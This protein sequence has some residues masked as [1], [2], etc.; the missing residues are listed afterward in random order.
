[1]KT[2]HLTTRTPKNLHLYY[3]LT[4]SAANRIFPNSTS[5]LALFL[6][7][8]I[9]LAP[10]SAVAQP[11]LWPNGDFESGLQGWYKATSLAD[12]QKQGCQPYD[13][14]AGTILQDGSRIPYPD[15]PIVRVYEGEHS[16]VLYSGTHCGTGHKTW[17]SLYSPVVTRPANAQNLAFVF[18]A[19]G[20]P[21]HYGDDEPPYVSIELRVNGTTTSSIKFNL[22]ENQRSLIDMIHFDKTVQCNTSRSGT[23]QHR[24]FLASNWIPCT[25][26]LTSIPVGAKIQ[27][28]FTVYNC[29]FYIHGSLLAVDRVGYDL[30]NATPALANYT[31]R[32]RSF[33]RYEFVFD[34]PV[35]PYSRPD[36]DTPVLDWNTQ[37][38]RLFKTLY[39]QLNS[40]FEILAGI[41]PPEDPNGIV[42][43][44]ATQSPSDGTLAL[45]KRANTHKWSRSTWKK[46]VLTLFAK[47]AGLK[48]VI[49]G[50]ASEEGNFQHNQWLAKGRAAKVKNFLVSQ[51]IPE[52]LMQTGFS[53]RT[54]PGFD[55]WTEHARGVHRTAKVQVFSRKNSESGMF[56]GPIQP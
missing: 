44:V 46:K 23:I 1:M 48:I 26:S 25:F 35:T 41:Y 42:D 30:H 27:L 17:S 31:P 13:Q 5:A 29:T 32:D 34:S 14:I 20:A 54:F 43:F 6:I 2:T 11:Q 47:R 52:E 7:T 36:W 18:L 40:Q 15:G 56:F 38:S 12:N 21:A 28:V 9:L 33:V 53:V 50:N 37:T 16:A 45:I 3:N 22:P 39:A 10:F 4:T 8:F 24:G 55:Q 49:E 19:G 51:G